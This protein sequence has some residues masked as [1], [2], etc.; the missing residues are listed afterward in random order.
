MKSMKALQI[1]STLLTA[2]LLASCASAPPANDS[3]KAA[4]QEG[5][6]QI[7]IEGRLQVQNK[8]E[9]KTFTL[10][11]AAVVVEPSNLRLDINGPFGKPL[12]KVVIRG[13]SMGL[14]VPQ[15]KKAYIG[16]VSE[17]SFKPVLPMTLHPRALMSFLMGDVPRDWECV[18]EAPDKQVCVQKQLGLMLTRDPRPEMKK[19]KW[20]VEGEKF[21]LVFLPTDI[22]TNVQPK[23]DTFAMAIPDG[24]S[25]HK[26][27]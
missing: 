16:A 25:R 3:R 6:R 26:L 9:K 5:S 2:A 15:Q 20:R 19:S 24:Y 21:S 7:A 17:H 12:G 8:E 22:K 27:P 1:L 18:F 13:D 10:T 14:L 11:M 23:P 4:P